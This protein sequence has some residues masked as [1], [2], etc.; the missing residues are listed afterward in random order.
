MKGVEGPQ[1]GKRDVW[2]PPGGTAGG[3]A[4]LRLTSSGHRLRP[5][6]P[7][8]MRHRPTPLFVCT[9]THRTQLA[10][11]K[12]SQG[13]A[14]ERDPQEGVGRVPALRV[15]ALA[16]ADHTRLPWRRRRLRRE[17][18]GTRRSSGFRWKLLELE[19]R[20]VALL[21]LQGE[22]SLSDFLIS[23][24]LSEYPTRGLPG[25]GRDYGRCWMSAAQ[26]PGQ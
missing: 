4:S 8:V 19:A 16:P 7:S 2:Y 20:A 10:P 9:H 12:P 17:K 25:M 14:R 22:A 3:L 24:H 18:A 26:R 5:L 6:W 15:V 13:T 21:F 23:L 11:S 1:G